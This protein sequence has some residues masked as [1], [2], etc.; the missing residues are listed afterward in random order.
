VVKALIAEAS[1]ADICMPVPA[2][3]ATGFGADIVVGAAGA[4]GAMTICD[5]LKFIGEVAVVVIALTAEVFTGVAN[6]DMSC[7]G[8]ATWVC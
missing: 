1:A 8:V 4:G 5:M 3:G 6:T 7:V 2:E